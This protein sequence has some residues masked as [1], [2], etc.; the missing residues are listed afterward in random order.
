MKIFRQDDGVWKIKCDGTKQ[1]LL[2]VGNIICAMAHE[3]VGMKRKDKSFVF[4][5]NDSKIT[6]STNVE[7]WMFG[8]GLISASATYAAK[9]LDKKLNEGKSIASQIMS[10]PAL[11]IKEE[12][13]V[14]TEE[15][16]EEPDA[17]S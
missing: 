13:S 1:E 17:K 9:L 15:K 2:D 6:T 4:Y 3:Q 5:F 10:A 16:K 11:E 7:F 14:K 12:V 8:Q